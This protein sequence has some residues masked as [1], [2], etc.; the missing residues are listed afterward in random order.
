MDAKK[1]KGIPVVSLEEGTNLGE[2]TQPLFDL[3]A[4]KL[5]AVEVDGEDGTFIVPFELIQTIGHDAMTIRSSQVTQTPETGDPVGTL[6]G[7]QDLEKLE[8]VDNEGTNLGTLDIIEFD[9]ETGLVTQLSAHKGGM[10]GM[11]GT[12]TPLDAS[13]ILKVGPELL[14]VTMAAGH[15]LP[16]E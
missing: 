15:A 16:A 14:T 3:A 4:R 8:V 9:P 1:L 2:I 11:G 12:T 7:L 13:S 10:L 6:K 5:R